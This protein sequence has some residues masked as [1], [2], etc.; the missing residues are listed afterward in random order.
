MADTPRFTV[1]VPAYNAEATIERTVASVIAQTFSDWELVICDDGSTDGTLE[2]VRALAREEGR[3]VVLSQENRGSGGAYNTAVRGSRGGLIVMLSAD[4]L[5]LPGHLAAMD[6]AVSL[7]SGISIWT[8]SGFYEYEDG[9]RVPAEPQA[10][11]KDPDHCTLE[12]L[13]RACWFGVGAV[14][15][16][17]VFDTVG[18]FRE[19]IYAEDYLFWLMALAHGYRHTHVPEPLSVHTVGAAQKSS[20]V[21]QM[22]EADVYAVRTA[23]DSG[24]L[25]DSQQVAARTALANLRR[26]LVIRRVAHRLIGARLAEGLIARVGGRS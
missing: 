23:L 2:V 12:E 26:N 5:L 14:F 15:R 8:C 20:R 22:R 13:F 11:W 16:R 18:G 25:D 3:T 19:D 21:I 1:A 9:S 6:R 17:E 10:A 7:D 24:L 4:D